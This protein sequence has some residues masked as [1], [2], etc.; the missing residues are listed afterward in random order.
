MIIG[1][2]MEIVA[3]RDGLVVRG[4]EHR[5]DGRKMRAV[6][7]VA[8]KTDED[9]QIVVNAMVDLTVFGPFDGPDVLLALVTTLLIGFFG[10]LHIRFQPNLSRVNAVDAIRGSDHLTF[11]V[12]NRIA[13]VAVFVFREGEAVGIM[14]IVVELIARGKAFDDLTIGLGEANRDF[15]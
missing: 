14:H 8:C 9:D 7:G 6:V 1:S 13:V 4:I 10:N 12:V 15:K 5:V 3:Q 2:M 11:T